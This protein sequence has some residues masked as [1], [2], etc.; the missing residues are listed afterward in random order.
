MIPVPLRVLA[1]N[2]RRGTQACN[3]DV[4]W[5]AS[6]SGEELIASAPVPTALWDAASRLLAAS[7][8]FQAFAASFGIDAGRPTTMASYGLLADPAPGYLTGS[9]GQVWQVHRAMLERGR[10]LDMFLDVTGWSRAEAEQSRTIQFLSGLLDATPT[11]IVVKDDCSRLVLV[12]EA[13]CR[14]VG[15][16]A[17]G[18]PGQHR[19][20]PLAARRGRPLRGPRPARARDRHRRCLRGG[21]HGAAAASGAGC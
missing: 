5:R 2:Q 18:S 21:P 1:G 9:N 11:P 6:G 10:S 7:R 17:R 19:L 15:P 12:N 20:R 14:L 16:A 3:P 13:F 4:W 8:S